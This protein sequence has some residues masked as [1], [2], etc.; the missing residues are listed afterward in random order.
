MPV[1]QEV[2]FNPIHDKEG[3][4]SA[5]SCFSRDITDAQNYQRK[6]E[7]QNEQLTKIAWILSHKVRAH[8]ANIMSLAA[9]FNH[10]DHTDL[11]N[12][13]IV[14]NLNNS[15]FLLDNVIKDVSDLTN[16]LDD[17]V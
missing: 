3:R 15:V 11:I 13:E 12:K 1:Y 10:D 16:R 5:I 14:N 4:V 8:V 17:P 7:I 6:I 9:L 2:S